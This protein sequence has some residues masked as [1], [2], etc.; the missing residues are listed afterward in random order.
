MAHNGIIVYVGMISWFIAKRLI[1]FVLAHHDTDLLCRFAGKECPNFPSILS[2]Y[3]D[4]LL[5]LRTI[6]KLAR[7]LQKSE[8]KFICEFGEV[9]PQ[10]LFIQFAHGKTVADIVVLWSFILSFLYHICFIKSLPRIYHFL[11]LNALPLTFACSFSIPAPGSVCVSSSH[12]YSPISSASAG[13]THQ[14][15]WLVHRHLCLAAFQSP[16]SFPAELLLP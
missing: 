9:R 11:V 14:D 13:C 12:A 7:F 6:K 10:K 4:I 3:S 15:I 16:I 8:R 2:E 5:Y 1:A